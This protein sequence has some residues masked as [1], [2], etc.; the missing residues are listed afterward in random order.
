M[1]GPV[2][3]FQDDIMPGNVGL[4]DLTPFTLSPIWRDFSPTRDRAR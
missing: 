3:L 1:R 4:Q 2:Y